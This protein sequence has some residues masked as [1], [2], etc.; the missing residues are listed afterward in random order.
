MVKLG[1]FFFH[2]RNGLFPLTYLLLFWKSPPLLPDYRVAAIL[3]L[4]VALAG[5]ALRAVTIG[6]DYIKRGGK[7]RQVYADH[8]V[9]G[10]IFAHCRNPLYLG[11]FTILVGLGLAANSWLFLLVGIPF[12]AF[13]YAAII[14]AE[15]NYL[16]QK[17]GVQFDD[18]CKRVNRLLPNP[19]G[20][21]VTLQSMEFS[22]QR[23]IVKE[24]GSTYAWMAGMTLLVMKNHWLRHGYR[25]DRGLLMI[26][27]GVLLAVTLAYAG[28][29]YAKKARILHAD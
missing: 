6:L 10:G 21:S 11:N 16:R 26:L 2:Y 23:L 4:M 7:D 20:L 17:F 28:A 8:L 19:A 25:D 29:R 14:A 22:W 15:E 18:Y 3:G 9:Q 12:F 5:Q 1:N 27:G 13:A 24:Y